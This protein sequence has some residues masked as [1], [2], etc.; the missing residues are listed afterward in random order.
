MGASITV[1]SLA[2]SALSLIDLT[3][4]NNVD[5]LAGQIVCCSSGDI[6]FV[7]AAGKLVNV[8]T[9]DG[10]SGVSVNN[11]SGTANIMLRADG[12]NIA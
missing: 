8:G 7:S 2:V 11:F 4:A 12:L 3:Q 1:P 9:V 10:L 6:N 5:N